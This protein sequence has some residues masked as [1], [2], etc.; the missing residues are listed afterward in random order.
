[1]Y[2]YLVSTYLYFSLR[3]SVIY[4]ESTVLS[5]GRSSFSSCFLF[6][7]MLYFLLFL[8]ALLPSLLR[9]HIRVCLNIFSSAH[10]L[11]TCVCILLQTAA[12]LLD[13]DV[14]KVEGWGVLVKGVSE[15]CVGMEIKSRKRG[16]FQ[17]LGLCAV[18]SDSGVFLCTTSLLAPRFS[19]PLPS[20]HRPVLLPLF[21]LIPLSPLPSAPPP[22]PCGTLSWPTAMAASQA[23][24]QVWIVIL[25]VVVGTRSS[26]PLVS[27]SSLLLLL[28]QQV[29]ASA[30]LR[31][32]T[33]SLTPLSPFIK[34]RS[35]ASASAFVCCRH[36]AAS[37]TYSSSSSP[38]CCPSCST[39]SSFWLSSY[40]CHPPPPPS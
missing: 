36:V 4:W 34:L 12:S 27:L 20:L 23:D 5:A 16:G 14:A 15:V 28:L 35:T 8:A 18:A 32:P 1:M 29:S 26:P 24:E 37:C 3:T 33:R 21:P 40:P 38:A 30:A 9:T 7:K 25:V 6:L 10:F 22:P 13:R 39:S 2:P 17:K 19:I 11:C 31:P